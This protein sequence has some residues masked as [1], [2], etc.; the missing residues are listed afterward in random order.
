[1]PCSLAAGKMAVCMSSHPPKPGK[2]W[3]GQQ[4][5]VRLALVG[6]ALG[7]VCLAAVFYAQHSTELEPY[8]PKCISHALT[9]WHCPGCGLTRSC[10]A[11][12]HGHWRQALAYNV[13]SP[14]ILT[15][16]S[17][18]LLR[19]V[20]YWIWPHQKPRA[21]PRQ[22]L[23]RVWLILL[24]SFVALYAVA[25]NLPWEPFCWLAPHE[26]QR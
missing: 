15:L 10:T 4:Q 11:L 21:K 19:G 7:L 23:Q 9:G 16:V 20:W 2:P 8:M 1:M 26:L 22:P 24:V 17:V 13:L 3:F 12:L 25:R 14:I 6:L 18:Q 5:L